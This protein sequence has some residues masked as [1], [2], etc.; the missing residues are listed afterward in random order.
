MKTY[1]LV[2]ASVAW[3]CFVPISGTD[4]AGTKK[5]VYVDDSAAE[6]GDGTAARPARTIQEGISLLPNAGGKVLVHPGTYLGPILVQRNRVHIQGL[7]NPVYDADGFLTGFTSDDASDQE[8]VIT[9]DRPLVDVGEFGESEDLIEIRGDDNQVRNV[10]VLVPAGTAEGGFTSALSAKAEDG[11]FYHAI[12]FRNIIVRGAVGNTAWTRKANVLFDSITALDGGFVGFN[13][14]ANGHVTMRKVDVAN[15][16][17]ANVWFL[18]LWEFP[19]SQNG[20]SL[21]T[22]VIKDSRL[23][24]AANFG[25][26]VMGQ[27]NQTNPAAETTVAVTAKNN[28][29]EGNLFGINVQPVFDGPPNTARRSLFLGVKDNTYIANTVD[30]RV[31]FRH[32][33]GDAGDAFVRDSTVAVKDSDGVFPSPA[34]VDLG[35][36]ENGNLYVLEH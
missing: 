16:F 20:P 35:P 10:V 23:R 17:F 9:I 11:Q 2:I 15:N 36:P 19:G 33:F 32:F 30:A 3:F 12:E 7:A 13:P 24:N 14:T 26:L 29:F 27:G 21:L 4:A 31:I 22:S 5:V 1:R 28:R 34:D 8:V 18:G 25:L 6:G